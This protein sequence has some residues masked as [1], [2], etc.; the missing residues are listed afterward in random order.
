VGREAV[1]DRVVWALIAAVVVLNV[2]LM[3]RIATG[4]V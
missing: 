1:G 4:G 2:V 3:W